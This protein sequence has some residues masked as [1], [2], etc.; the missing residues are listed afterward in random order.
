MKKLF[1]IREEATLSFSKNIQFL[2]APKGFEVSYCGKPGVTWDESAQLASSEYERGRKELDDDFTNQL[3]VVRDDLAKRQKSLLSKIQDEASATIN[4][5][6]KR[7]PELVV[8]LFHHVLPGVQIDG[9]A[10]EKLVISLIE[11]F[12]DETESLDVYL[13]PDDLN[14][15][16]AFSKPEG[17]GDKQPQ[18]DQNDGFANAI[19][20]IFDNLD[21]DD[22]LLPNYPNVSFHEDSSLSSGDC[23]IKSRFGLLDGRIATKLRRIEASMSQND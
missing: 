1:S 16:K 5:L 22:S 3:S 11:E 10:V 19:S 8:N 23:Q 2:S 7:L 17:N 18:S 14:L 13:C 15:L 21:G 9:N 6:E 20:G 12:A 4:E